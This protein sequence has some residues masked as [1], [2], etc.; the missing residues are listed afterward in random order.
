M[1][2]PTQGT[3]PESDGIPVFSLTDA[4]ASN[5]TDGVLVIGGDYG[6]E[7]FYDSVSAF[8]VRQLV[9]AVF[10]DG[11]WSRQV[12]LYGNPVEATALSTSLFPTNDDVDNFL[13]TEA[14]TPT[15]FI[16]EGSEP[17]DP[18]TGGGDGG[19]PES[20]GIPVFSLTDA[21][22]SN[23]TDGVLVIGGDYG[24]EIFYDSV[25]AFEVRQL[26]PAVFSDGNW[27]RQV[28]LY[29]NPVEATALSTSLFPTNDDVDN[30]L[31]TEALTP[32]GFIIEGS[33]PSDPGTGGGDGGDPESDGIPVFSL[34]DAQASNMTDGV[35][36][37]G[38]DY[39]VE[40]FYD[41]VSAFEVR[42]LVPAVFS[43]GNWSRQVDLY[44]NPV[45]AT[46]L[47]TSLFPTNDDV[48]NFLVTE[49]LTPADL[50]SKTMN[51]PTPAPIQ[52]PVGVMAVKGMGL[53]S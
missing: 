49:A 7:I 2:L 40:I 34:T 47:S 45:E 6:V 42:Q 36:V 4:Q 31:V 22:A 25:S 17:S 30:F 12:D 29:G 33:E 11:N 24:V 32:T 18:G 10:S 35:L 53:F 50:L 43:D 37:I 8:E 52:A 38:G 23:M 9:P 15:G 16:I 3:D 21:Q 39:G 41:S 46:A 19:D 1:K 27:S 5:M 28:D 20:D 26:V 48:D 44:G 51:T 13:V 14:L